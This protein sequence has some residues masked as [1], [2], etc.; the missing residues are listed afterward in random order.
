[1]SFSERFY[2]LSLRWQICALLG[3]SLVACLLI[4]G[5]LAY[6]RSREAI[7][8]LTL[9]R[10]MAET[11]QAASELENILESTRLDTVST[12]TFPPIPGMIRCWDNDDRITDVEGNSTLDDW[13]GRLKDILT[14]QMQAHPERL[15]CT[16]YNE[17]GAAVMRVDSVAG[18]SQLVREGLDDVAEEDYFTRARNLKRGQTYIAPIRDDEPEMFVRV[19]APCFKTLDVTDD[20]VRGVFIMTLDGR[21]ILNDVARFIR[22]GTV[23][24][25]DESGA[26]LMPNRPNEDRYADEYPVRFNEMSNRDPSADSY[27]KYISADDRPGEALIATYQKVFYDTQ[28][29]TRFWLVAP[30]IPAEVALQ[31]ASQLA[32]SI[33]TVGL[34]VLLGTGAIAF[35]LLGRLTMPLQRLARAADQVAGGQ[36]DAPLPEARPIG[37]VKALYHSIGSMTTNL[38][39]MIDAASAEEART[40]AIFDST[41]DAIVTI[42]E[43]GD[44]LSCNAT[45][46]LMFGHSASWLVGQK[47]SVIV[48][49]LYQEG[50]QYARRELARGEVRQLGDE[51]ETTGHHLDGDELPIAMRISELE[52]AGQRLYIATMQDI[53]ARQQARE[54][55]HQLFSAIRDAVS[56]LAAGTQQILS[57]TTQQ[58]TG[59]QQ[60]AAAVSQTVAT[61]DEVAQTA[62]QA[63]ERANAVAEAAKRAEEVGRAGRQA[64][65]DSVVSMGTVRDQVQSIA[66]NILSLAER[67]QAIGEIIATVSDIAEQTN[68]LALNAAVEASRAGEHG[69]GFAV[70]AT[71]VKALAAQSKKATLQVRQILGE[72]QQAMNTAVLSTEKGTDSVTKAAQIVTQTGGTIQSLEEMLSH[73]ARTATQISASAGQQATGVIQLNEAIKN[74]DRVTRQNVEAIRQIEASAQNLN[75]LSNELAGL[76]SHD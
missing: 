8:E 66:E 59:A 45:T 27:K 30:S 46:E 40:K 68:I 56:R 36:L 50:T 32:N 55:R 16:V 43:Q 10:V 76:T 3:V 34:F 65:D 57:T 39:A 63:A 58:A 21:K 53:T 13:I 75:A 67:A 29:R 4:T 72:I 23:C 69:K 9:D 49:I 12:P 1:M 51:I 35:V 70:V 19:C 24:I 41:A 73:S 28:D 20:E 48:P 6:S 33:L 71:E 11:N 64:V 5:A 18:K 47:A 22:S 2:S 14:A 44:V 54:E 7:I 61:V 38:R 42:D 74:I 52:H 60:Q 37:E 17:S 62:D 25:V 26:Y 31:P 15:R